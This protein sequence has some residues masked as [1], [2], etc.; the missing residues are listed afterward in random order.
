[1]D[2]T[3]QSPQERVEKVKEIISNTPPENLT[4]R[5]LDAMAKYIVTPADKKER[6]QHYILTENR[7]Q[8]INDREISYEGL[9]GKLENGEDGIYNMIINDKN[10]LLCPKDKITEEDIETI[11][12]L[13]E[14]QE[15]IEKCKAR[16]SVASGK[17]RLTLKNQIIAM[18]S[19]MHT[20]KN[21][22][23]RLSFS[24]SLIKTFSRLDLSE[25]VSFNQE[26]DIV[27]DGI[28]NLYNPQ[29]IMA[30]LC[31]YEDLKAAS[32]SKVNEDMKWFLFD[33][34]KLI[35]DTLKNNYPIY[36]DILKSKIAGMSNIE[37]QKLIEDNHGVKHTVEYISA[38]WRN[39]IPKLL[40]EQAKENWL[41]WHYTYEERGNWKRCNRC[42]SI[43]LAHNRFFSK[44]SASKDNFYSICKEC[45]N[46]KS[47]SKKIL[48]KNKV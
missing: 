45:R 36:Y 18:Y 14:M 21:A 39:K 29:H 48:P 47:S 6:K 5:Y 41:I 23:N 40:A 42:G 43:K 32:W 22:Y 33:L 28:I 34:D 46:K 27:S 30:L 13:K 15:E 16:M 11:P 2:W 17:A 10:A 3:L 37:I 35:D 25:N 38:L 9:A 7:M 31:N 8:V 12:G 1:M 44:N 24:K 26:G 4:S 20:I 19:D